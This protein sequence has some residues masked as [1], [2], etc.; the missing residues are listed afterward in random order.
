MIKDFLF[1]LFKLS[2]MALQHSLSSLVWTGCALPCTAITSNHSKKSMWIFW[3][4]YAKAHISVTPDG[5]A[6][7]CF[8]SLNQ[9]FTAPLSFNSKCLAGGGHVL[10]LFL[11]FFVRLVHFFFFFKSKTS[12]HS[13]SKSKSTG[14]C[15]R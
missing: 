4:T 8:R 6:P 2:H 14:W 9:Y 7:W 1:V 3:C 13:S 11:P 15:C 12:K 5:E 10:L